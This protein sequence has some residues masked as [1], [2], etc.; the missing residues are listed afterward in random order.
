MNELATT[1]RALLQAIGAAPLAFAAPIPREAAK[2]TITGLETFRLKVNHRGDWVIA[3]LLTGGGIAGLGDA[4]HG[5]A[6]GETITLMR[7]YVEQLK[8]RGVF[9]IE[10]LRQWGVQEIARRGKVAAVAVSALE[11]AL[12]DIQGQALG[13]PCYQLFGGRLRPTIRNYANINRSTTDRTPAGFARMAAKAV[14]AGFDAFKLAP[15]DGMPRDAA[16]REKHINNAVDCA[17]AVREAIGPQRDLLL[18]VH[19]LVTLEHGL[20]LVERL[21]PLKLF[22]LEEVTREPLEN[23]AAIK[24]AAQAVKMPIAGG[25]SL[26]DA[27]AFY[28]YAAAGAADILMPDVKYCGGLLE[29]RKVAALAEA[30]GLTIAPHGPASPVGNFAVAHLCAGMPNFHILEFSFGEVPWREELVDPPERIERG[31]LA[32]PDRPGF[33]VTL[34]PRVVKKYLGA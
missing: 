1:R 10:W 26:P 18:D 12:W 11:Q 25:E 21:A 29:L 23:L 16:A 3:R 20:K 2:L 27:K 19:S 15:W 8:G 28:R 24:R 13:V 30:M 31:H 32:A 7:Q 22:W 5:G 33:G 14:A 9:D 6:D 17:F 34:N 4:S